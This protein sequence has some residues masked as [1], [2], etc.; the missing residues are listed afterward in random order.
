[1][2]AERAFLFQVLLDDLEVRLEVTVDT[3]DVVSTAGGAVESRLH[4]ASLDGAETEPDP[5]RRWA[6]K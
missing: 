6:K 5:T 2:E 4:G 3:D 1:M